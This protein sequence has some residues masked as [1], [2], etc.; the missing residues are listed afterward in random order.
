M[1]GKQGDVVRRDAG[2]FTLIELM[3]AILI[4]AILATLTIPK[5]TSASL[6]ARVSEAVS[7]LSSFEKAQAVALSESGETVSCDQLVIENPCTN[8][9]SR[10]FSYSEHV[11]PLASARLTGTAKGVIAPLAGKSIWTEV[12]TDGTV[13]H[14][15]DDE[16]NSLAPNW[17]D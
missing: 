5:V 1:S 7:T 6:R 17:K 3:I 10:Y 13:E 12:Q 11:A 9:Y 14:G 16:Y 8:G 15:H 2:G 4:V